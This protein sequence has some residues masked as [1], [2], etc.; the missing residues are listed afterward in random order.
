MFFF[1]G[2]QNQVS[3]IKS[4]WQLHHR[5]TQKIEFKQIQLKK[6]TKIVKLK[7][8]IT[9][10]T[11][12]KSKSK[13][14]INSDPKI[15]IKPEPTKNIKAKNPQIANVHNTQSPQNTTLL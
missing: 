14:D 4:Q 9:L 15:N 13:T 6:L 3:L 1:F 2:G 11:G 5:E 7:I 12:I 10:I 8:G